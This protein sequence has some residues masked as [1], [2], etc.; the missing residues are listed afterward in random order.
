MKSFTF[1]LVLLVAALSWLAPGAQAQTCAAPTNVSVT[2][3]SDS[4]VVVTFTPSPNA[5]SYTVRYYWTG[6]STATGI[7]TVT[8]TTSPMTLWGLHVGSYYVVS[9]V[10]NCAGGGTA[11]S[12]TQVVLITGTTTTVCAAPSAV[13]ATATGTTTASVSFAAVAGANGYQV[14]YYPLGTALTTTVNTIASP[15]ALSGLQP[16][17]QYGI[18]VITNCGSGAQS[19]PATATVRTNAPAAPCATVG[20]ISTSTTTSTATLNFTPVSGASSYTVQYYAVG[21]SV[22]T[23]TIVVSGSPVTLAGLLPNTSYVVRV[24]TNCTATSTSGPRMVIVHTAAVPVPCGAVSNIV[25]TGTSATS[26][27]VSFTPGQ[28]NTS[29]RVSYYTGTDSARWV[30][31]TSSPVV[32]TGLVPGQTYT[33]TV[34]SACGTGGTVV[35]TAGAPVTYSF[36]GVL[37]RRNALDTGSVS[38]FPNPAHQA[39]TL[40]LPAAAGNAQARLLLLNAM[41]QQVRTLAVPLGATETRTQLD[42]AGLAPGLYTVQVRVGSQ[43]ASQHLAVE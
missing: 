27:T 6:D 37:A 11:A 7:R 33:I 16:N 25:V 5:V 24:F 9:V 2:S 35:F 38:V 32:L 31:S 19:A 17:T 40:V 41:G 8:T 21:D 26:A 34:S 20:N 28:N 30:L 13:T 12:P 3:S 22:N 15:V 43:T 1:L 23:H 36:R 10:S 18:R 29:F 4:T 14:Q 39:A 42:L